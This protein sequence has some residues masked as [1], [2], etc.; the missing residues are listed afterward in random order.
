MNWDKIRFYKM[1]IVN[2]FENKKFFKWLFFSINFNIQKMEQKKISLELVPEKYCR[3]NTLPK[4]K[5][6]V[7]PKASFY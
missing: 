7:D 3:I 6:L 4:L 1:L 5:F 2:K